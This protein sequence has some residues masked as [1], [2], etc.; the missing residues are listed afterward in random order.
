VEAVI[1]ADREPAPQPYP[2][3]W[4]SR[5]LPVGL[6]HA[7]AVRAIAARARPAD[8]VYATGMHGRAALATAVSRT[9]LVLKMTSDPAFERA[10]RR[11]AV[12]GAVVQFQ[13]G[14]GGVVGG[15]L[16][17]VRDGT[18]RRAAHVVCPSAYMAELVVGWGVAP[19]R[20]TVLPNP[21]PDPRAAT[22]ASLDH[23]PAV[24][25]AGRLT[26][27]KDLELGL[28]AM[29]RIGS[30][31]LTVVGDGPDRARLER[32]RDELDVPAS[33]LG[34]RPRGEVLGL[35]RAADVVML[36]S[37]WEN[38]PH[39]VVEALAM[40]TPVVAT[41]VGG[42]PEVVRDEEN[43]LL[44]DPGDIDAFAG[45]LQRLVGDDALRTRLAAAAAPS[46]ERFSADKI[47]GMLEQIL[48]DAT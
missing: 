8:V 19:D 6:R 15:A 3:H 17:G 12:G 18:V 40:G 48:E 13:E 35:M 21:A 47:Y 28:R 30:A 37:A 27:A 32:L 41:R 34:A 5:R 43:G 24:V 45:A 2:V 38:F 4:V 33:F 1:T 20:T 22:P 46:V 7:E 10:R 42:V 23:H 44:V 39:G 16:R 9:G 11:G 14:G 36:P 29:A 25:F 31:A 26:A